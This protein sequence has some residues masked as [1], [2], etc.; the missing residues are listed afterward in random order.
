MN[1]EER[2]LGWDGRYAQVGQL[3]PSD[4]ATLTFPINERTDVIHIE[5]QPYT[6]V[7]KGNE[8]VSIDP[9]G[10]YYSLYQRDHYRQDSA[11]MRK[12]ERFIPKQQVDW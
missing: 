5:K 12:V 4:T 6:L 10:R 9:P 1:G 7:R 2:R 3:K 11:R 8:V